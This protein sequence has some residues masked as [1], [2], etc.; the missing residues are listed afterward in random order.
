M[1]TREI[2]EATRR[3][4]ELPKNAASVQ[5][6]FDEAY[7]DRPDD[8][9]RRARRTRD[10]MGVALAETWKRLQADYFS[11]QE[12][13]ETMLDVEAALSGGRYRRALAERFIGGRWGG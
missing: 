12:V 11:Y 7:R 13:A 10:Y 8:F 2:A 3:V 4:R 5:P 6:V 9:R 1:I